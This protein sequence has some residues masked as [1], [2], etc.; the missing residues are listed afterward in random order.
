[1]ERKDHNSE[2]RSI[3]YG[4][5]VTHILHSLVIASYPIRI[6]EIPFSN[7]HSFAHSPRSSSSWAPSAASSPP[8]CPSSSCTPSPTWS[9]SSR[10]TPSQ[11]SRASTPPSTT[12]TT[13]PPA[14]SARCHWT[15]TSTCDETK[16]KLNL[17]NPG[18]TKAA[19]NKEFRNIVG[20]RI[21]VWSCDQDWIEL[22][23]YCDTISPNLR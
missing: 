9:A 16:A 2:Q 7:R 1:M 19:R 14:T 4:L 15:R 8:S 22:C 5:K 11:R 17:L 13:T 20:Q 6:S 3:L 12:P 21:K 18:W 23:T 10:P